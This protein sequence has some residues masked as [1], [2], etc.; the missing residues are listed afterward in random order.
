MDHVVR[1][2]L[3]VVVLW[4]FLRLVRWL[5]ARYT[6]ASSATR[7]LRTVALAL[8]FGFVVSVLLI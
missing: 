6:A 8:A 5:D 2:G 7:E 1:L 3:L 4:A